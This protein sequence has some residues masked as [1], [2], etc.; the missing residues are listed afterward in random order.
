MNIRLTSI[1]SGRPSSRFPL[2][3][4]AAAALGLVTACSGG[5]GDSDNNDNSNKNSESV[6][7]D[8]VPLHTLSVPPCDF[9]VTTGFAGNLEAI[10]ENGGGGPG[11]DG[12]SGGS[13]GA[14][15]G[16]SKVLGALLEVRRI[17]DNSL[18]GQAKTDDVQGLVT[19]HT[20]GKPEALLVTLKGQ[21]GAKFFDEGKNTYVDFGEGQELHALVTGL[22]ENLG[23]S[24]FTEAAYRY[25][26]N[27]H[28]APSTGLQGKPLLRKSQPVEL[29]NLT[30]AQIKQANQVVLDEI[31][32]KLPAAVG[33]GYRM[34]SL[35]ALPTPVDASS[36]PQAI[37]ISPYGLAAVV[38]GGFTWMANQLNSGADLSALLAGD[39]LA[40][41][42][43]DG[44]IDGYGLNGLAAS[45]GTATYDSVRLPVL[46]QTGA[47]AVA[48]SFSQA[49]I[50]VAPEFSDIT[51]VFGCQP[52]ILDQTLALRKDG[53]VTLVQHDCSTDARNTTL[54]AWTAIAQLAPSTANSG[55]YLVTS[56]KTAGAPVDQLPGGVVLA[57]G[58]GHCGALGD[59]LD[60]GY[61]ATARQIPVLKNI[62]SLASGR[63]YAIARDSAGHVWSW[64]HN[65]Y[66]NLGRPSLLSDPTCRLFSGQDFLTP[67]SPQPQVIPNLSD[68]VSVYATEHTASAIDKNGA[69]YQWGF[70][71]TNDTRTFEPTRVTGLGKVRSIATIGDLTFVVQADGTVMGWGRKNPNVFVAGAPD[72][73]GTPKPVPGI[74]GVKEIASDTCSILALMNDGSVKRWGGCNEATKVVQPT[75]IPGLDGVVIRHLS[76]AQFAT[77]LFLQDGS[78]RVYG[79]GFGV[80]HQH[81][82]VRMLSDVY[83][84]LGAETP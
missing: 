4:V 83:P 11:G 54:K 42:L 74:S 48:T 31:N 66:G 62:T 41:D 40:N 44:K 1:L 14:G 67:F 58:T 6:A 82:G 45:T 75:T 3:C 21:A 18:V 57:S 38:T 10:Y 64:G 65:L 79:D 9:S 19:I 8:N 60:S 29:G 30:A 12:S 23:V 37:P 43:T 69:L 25:A 73:S 47:N 5:G 32:R 26:I 15:G 77:Y 72:R 53:S 28:L 36:G 17:A 78:L 24:A 84:E 70:T 34:T 7:S 49:N 61:V 80:D 71:G 63:A 51:S 27:N 13:A 35:T 50:K 20:C 46:L 39:E 59:G 33:S 55:F 68:I 52:G 2:H 81:A 22:Y 56:Q 16:E 76:E